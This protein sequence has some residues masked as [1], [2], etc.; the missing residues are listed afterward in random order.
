MSDPS[1]HACLLPFDTDDVEFARGF[2][3][4][5]LWAL[6]RETEEEV[7][8]TVHAANAEMILRL[9]EAT[10]RHVQ[11]VELDE[12]WIEATFSEAD[13]DSEF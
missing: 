11:A 3:T 12:D 7:V 2:E 4:G 6:L 13:V 8:E 10:G 9:A 5:R 1:G